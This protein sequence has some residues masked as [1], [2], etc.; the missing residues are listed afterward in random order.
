MSVPAHGERAPGARGADALG[1]A[2]QQVTRGLARVEEVLRQQERRA[3]A[4]AQE[5]ARRQ[6]RR[7]DAALREA[8]ARVEQRLREKDEAGRALA[9]RVE[10]RARKVEEWITAVEQRLIP[11][12][13]LKGARELGASVQAGELEMR[14]RNLEASVQRALVGKPTVNFTSPTSSFTSPVSSSNLPASFSIS[15]NISSTG[16]TSNPIASNSSFTISSEF[17]PGSEAISGATSCTNATTPFRTNVTS[18]ATSTDSITTSGANASF[19][20]ID[21]NT[22]PTPSTNTTPGAKD[23][24]GVDASSSTNATCGANGTSSSSSRRPGPP[25]TSDLAAA[26]ARRPAPSAHEKSTVA[27]QRELGEWEQAQKQRVQLRVR[28]VE[29]RRDNARAAPSSM[30]ETLCNAVKIGKLD[31]IQRLLDSAAD[32]NYIDTRGDCPLLLALLCPAPQEDVARVLVARGAKVNAVDACGQT[33]LHRAAAANR[34]WRFMSLLICAGGDANARSASGATP[35]HSAAHRGN[36]AAV[37]WL[38]AAG[39]SKS[40]KC[41]SGM[42]SGKTPFDVARSDDVRELL[43]P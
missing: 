17:I 23:T 33:A 19:G 21:T 6:E 43:R 9:Q 16:S 40:L 18:L 4:C 7:T 35:L 38:L 15:N 14:M 25:D 39:A 27:H 31:D 37:R 41:W 1:D 26:D 28:E 34:G 24:S 29:I 42:W 20:A 32:V 2:F 11:L 13:G 3:A 8:L 30:G 22:N 5:A 36:E 12:V 10:A